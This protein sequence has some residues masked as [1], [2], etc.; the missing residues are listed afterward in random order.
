MGQFILDQSRLSGAV[1]STKA[2]PMEGDFR[3]IQFHWTQSVSS[4]DWEGHYWEF[5]FDVSGVSEE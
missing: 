3:D 2:T 1:F 5:H 4:Q